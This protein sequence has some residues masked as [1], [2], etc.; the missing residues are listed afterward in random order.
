MYNYRY[1]LRGRR[2][3]SLR[4]PV[5]LPD[6]FLLNELDLDV[7]PG[8][9]NDIC[10]SSGATVVLH[11]PAC[12]VTCIAEYLRDLALAALTLVAGVPAVL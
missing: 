9:A 12:G 6:P 5:P 11:R 1:L 4:L 7:H 3:I 8:D 10:G 2:R